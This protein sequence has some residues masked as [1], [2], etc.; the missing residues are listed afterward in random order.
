MQQLFFVIETL[1]RVEVPPGTPERWMPSLREA[2]H[3]GILDERTAR[4]VVRRTHIVRPP[5]Q[6]WQAKSRR[7]MESWTSYAYYGSNPTVDD[8][9]VIVSSLA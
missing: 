8:E 6:S 4:V 9:D 1:V 2:A 7:L 5:P 3:T